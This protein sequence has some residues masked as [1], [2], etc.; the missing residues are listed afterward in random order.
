MN[1]KIKSKKESGESAFST[2][3]KAGLLAGI[4]DISLALLHYYIKTAKD[5]LGVLRFISKTAFGKT[6]FTDPTILAIT[7]L[8]VHFGIT[9][10]WTIIFFILYPQLKWLQQNRIITAFVYG[11]FTW[12]M[13]NM[14]ILPLW[15]NKAFI[16]DWSAVATGA[17]ILI[18]AI[19]LPLSFIFSKYY[20]KKLH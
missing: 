12:V 10:G 13:M 11:V 20:S 18:V 9:L 6:T 17:G 19:G 3:I 15:N 16:F 7:G 4:L 14:V 8:L 5:P 2:I 1:N